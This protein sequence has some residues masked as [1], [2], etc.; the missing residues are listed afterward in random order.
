MVTQHFSIA[1][2]PWLSF[3]VSNVISTMVMQGAQPSAPMVFTW[4]SH[5]I[6]ALSREGI[7]LMVWYTGYVTYWYWIVLTSVKNFNKLMDLLINCNVIVEITIVHHSRAVCREAQKTTL[8]MISW[9]LS[10][11]WQ[12][13]YSVWTSQPT[14]CYNWLPCTLHDLTHWGRVTHICIVKLTIIGSDNGLAPRQRQAIVWTNAE[15]LL[16][17]PLGTNFNEI[18][19]GIQTFSLTKMHSKLSS[20]KWRPFCLGLNVLTHWGLMMDISINE[21]HHHWFSYW[22]VVC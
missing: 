14:C 21:L 22:L 1:M 8:S 12:P 20:A 6:P 5:A 2:G 4:I 17:G 7:K 9:S 3:V 13:K 11:S 15:I 10:A 18:G 19:I 16:I